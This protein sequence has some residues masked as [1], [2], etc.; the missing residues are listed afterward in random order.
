MEKLERIPTIK[1]KAEQSWLLKRAR[2]L[3]LFAAIGA[4]GQFLRDASIPEVEK[5]EDKAALKIPDQFSIGSLEEQFKVILE[6]S[7]DRYVVVIGQAHH[8]GS[9]EQMSQYPRLQKVVIES[10]KNVAKIISH[11]KIKEVVFESLAPEGVGVF[12]RYRFQADQFRGYINTGDLSLAIRQVAAIID[13]FRKDYPKESGTMREVRSYFILC[14]LRELFK[15][16]GSSQIPEA[17]KNIFANLKNSLIE[18]ENRPS[19][20]GENKWLWGGPLISWC[21]GGDLSLV[22]FESVQLQERTSRQIRKVNQKRSDG[23]ITEADIEEYVALQNQREDLILKGINAS[24]WNT[25][26][27]FIVIG[28]G[29]DF[30]LNLERIMPK[31]TGLVVFEPRNKDEIEKIYI[32]E[33]VPLEPSLEDRH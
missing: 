25:N 20:A 3:V 29:H 13:E 28:S 31:N 18:L 2:E 27:K 15:G 14:L 26:S 22:G 8:W 6:K 7:G 11:L 4:G 19:I 16:V 21:E 32:E 5:E 1:N 12:K 24:P 33:K 10:Q 17:E 30:S 9:F 23:T